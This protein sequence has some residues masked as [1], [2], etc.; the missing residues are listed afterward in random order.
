MIR[1]NQYISFMVNAYIIHIMTLTYFQ[2]IW[3]WFVLI[4]W[5]LGVA[6][7]RAYTGQWVCSQSKRLVLS[8]MM[9]RVN[10]LLLQGGYVGIQGGYVCIMLGYP[11]K[12]RLSS[13]SSTYVNWA[14]TGWS[15]S[16]IQSHWWSISFGTQ[17]MWVTNI[18]SVLFTGNSMIFFNI[19]SEWV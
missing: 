1:R 3:R 11:R 9:V 6:E 17:S 14:T 8:V 15:I 12:R 2:G 7:P 13:L 5:M 18:F 4:T 10:V 19:W 16:C